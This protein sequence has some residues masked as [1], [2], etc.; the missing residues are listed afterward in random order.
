MIIAPSACPMFHSWA[1]SQRLGMSRACEICGKQFANKSNL[2]RHIAMKHHDDKS[3]TEDVE[4]VTDEEMES[5][6]SESEESGDEI[7]STIKMNT[8]FIWSFMGEECVRTGNSL[9]EVYKDKVLFSRAMKKDKTHQ[10]IMKTLRNYQEE[11]DEMDFL[12]ALSLAV[13]KRR[14]LIGRQE[15]YHDNDVDE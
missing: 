14:Y 7:Q 12:E 5:D 8:S 11:E 1:I 4:E 15:V 3:E 9:A 2:N 6:E 13:D 10:A